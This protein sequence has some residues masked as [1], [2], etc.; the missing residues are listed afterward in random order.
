MAGNLLTYSGIITK[1]KAMQ[2]NLISEQ[3]YRIMAELGSVAEFTDFLKSKDS[4]SFLFKGMEERKLHRGEIE[5][6]LNGSLY[7]DFASIY[8]FAGGRQR[9]VLSLHLFRFE[10]IMLKNCLQHVFNKK[11]SS[12]SG[13]SS[14]FLRRH[15]DLDPD[16][17]LACET[18]DEFIYALRKTRYEAIF[19]VPAENEKNLL[20]HYET[21]LDIY[22]FSNVWKLV[23]KKLSGIDRKAMVEIT[24]KNIDL[25]NIIWIYR[26]KKYYNMDSSSL[27]TYII[28]VNYKLKKEQLLKL[29]ETETTEEFSSVLKSTYYQNIYNILAGNDMETAKKNIISHIYR[30]NAKKY[31]ASMAPVNYYLYLK[32]Q[33]IDRITTGLECIRYNLPADEILKY[34]QR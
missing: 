17:L 31:P 18:L 20:F 16:A 28:P 21:Q 2:K 12:P 5:Q 11:T 8:L 32:E 33:E 27:Y 7:H 3:D 10:I 24:G 30:Q 9:D 26:S 4:Y 25:L 22:Y 1:V 14:V 6:L 15:S 29:M 34:L 19:T 23:K 13:F